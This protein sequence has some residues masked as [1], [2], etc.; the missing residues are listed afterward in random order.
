MSNLCRQLAV[1]KT[2]FISPFLFRA[3]ILILSLLAS[4]IGCAQ[5]ISG[6][7][8]DSKSQEPLP[9]ANVFLNNTTIGTVTDLG[10]E[11]KLKN[12]RQ[13]AVYEIVISFVGYESLKLKISLEGSELNIGTV[14]LRPSDIELNSLEVKG[15]KDTQW[16]KKMKR[17]KKIF[18]GE[19]AA[20]EAC[21]IVNPWVI[22]FPENGKK[23]R[24]VTSAPIEIENKALGYKLK[25]YL[26]NFLAD[27]L[28]YLIEGNTLFEE[29]KTSDENEMTRWNKERNK[30]YLHSTQH[31]FKSI[32][33]DRINGEGF[34]LYTDAENN[35]EGNDRR[36]EEFYSELGKTVL[37]FDTVNLLSRTEKE[38]IYLIK[39][40]GRLEVH[41]RK[42]KA[43]VRTYRDVFG[44]VSWMRLKKDYVVVTR[45][46]VALN[47]GDVIVSGAL[48]SERVAHLLPLDFLPA[49]QLFEEQTQNLLP[50]LE[51]HIYIHTDKPYYYPG[52]S[53]WFKGYINYRSPSLRDSLSQTVYVEL[54]NRAKQKILLQAI[55]HID[56][57]LFSGALPLPDSVL[58]RDCYLRAYTNL[59]RNFGDENIYIKPLP[60]V[61]ITDEVDPLQRKS[62]FNKDTSLVVTSDKKTYKPREKI[63]LTIS[64]KD[65]EGQPISS[66]LSLAVTDASQVTPVEVAS[67]GGILDAYP[68]RSDPIGTIKE[69]L[70]YPVEYGINFSGRFLG[71]KNKP[72]KAMLN[73][74]QL[75]PRN[76][77]I[78]QSDEK[79]VFSVNGLI[80]FDTAVFSIQAINQ[81]VQ[82]YGKV[83]LLSR[84]Q[85]PVFFPEV[86]YRLDIIKTETPQA[87]RRYWQTSG[88]SIIL[89]EIVVSA[90]KTR[91]EYTM[92]YRVKRPYGAPDH[93][94]RGKDIN[95]SYGNLLMA[96]P[97]KFPGL[98]VRLADNPGDGGAHY[99]VYLQRAF[100][101]GREVLVTVNDNVV[102]GSPANILS[103]IDP[104]TVES[105]ELK[106][107]ISVMYGAIGGSGVLSIYT[108]NGPTEEEKGSSI[109]KNVPTLKVMGYS[110]SPIFRSPNYSDSKTSSVSRDD[111]SL[112]YWNPQIR[113]DHANST[114]TV[115]FFASDLKGTYCV[116]TEGVSQNG[117]PLRCVSYVKVNDR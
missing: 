9:F 13:P 58:G 103:A 26:N 97:G 100:Y 8:L 78:A 69:S 67:E 70:R 37:P 76:F 64:V 75:N 111:R 77:T 73:V 19:D 89:K 30:S 48:N 102:G 23:F 22:D 49:E 17:F 80:F 96:L 74:I 88:K 109:K 66:D 25:F 108:K 34:N 41:Y 33:D 107:G 60:V 6:K 18:L 14:N 71:E 87:M 93:I 72:E 43:L 115:S 112:L 81:K 3:T 31:L 21:V 59:N 68:L 28:S 116:V 11:F 61:N 99:V 98:I 44:L 38:G 113:T 84:E 110:R 24:A 105:V 46:G 55:Y 90:P 40:K 4:F 27:N 91:E 92:E 94:L 29:L 114:T 2:D 62:L 20:A 7:V 1:F 5:A 32:I 52:D 95:S 85:I 16:E 106:K 83:E 104:A 65:D 53:I 82:A 12:V 42:E 101:S 39:I 56:S 51:E 54:V 57:G 50:F 36:S 86:N 35:G 45:N 10:G 63:T 117:K 47:P 15:T 79:G